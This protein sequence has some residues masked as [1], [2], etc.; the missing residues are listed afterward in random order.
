MNFK[1]S[2]AVPLFSAFFAMRVAVTTEAGDA[3]TGD[4]GQ[5]CHVELADDLGRAVILLAEVVDVAPVA[6]EDQL[7][8]LERLPALLFLPGDGGLGN[9]A[10]LEPVDQGATDP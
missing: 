10:V 7:A 1:K 2:T 3:R 9:V 5:G 6:M 8:V 4:A